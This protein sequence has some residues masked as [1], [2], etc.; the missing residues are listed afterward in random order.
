MT[1]TGYAK[2]I[3]KGVEVNP[4]K[5]NEKTNK[6]YNEAWTQTKTYYFR[7]GP[8]QAIADCPSDAEFEKLVAIAYPSYYNK[9]KDFGGYNVTAYTNDVKYPNIAFFSDVSNK[10]FTKG[11]LKW[12]LYQ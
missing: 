2:E 10:I 9:V 7:T 5:Y 12:R 1:V 4:L 6:Y 8:S 3:Q 11:K